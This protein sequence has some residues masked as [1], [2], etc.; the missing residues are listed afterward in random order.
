[1]YLSRPDG[2]LSTADLRDISLGGLR[3]RLKRGA[4]IS[5]ARGS[6][7]A[8]CAIDLP[9]HGKIACALEVAHARNS[10]SRGVVTFGGRFIDL[11]QEH[12]SV[13]QRFVAGL[14]R[15]TMKVRTR[16]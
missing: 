9:K 13:I 11:S 15:D 6:H 16:V 1:M 5:V 2:R 10:G 3:A 8:H 7:I 4:S 12:R 14:E